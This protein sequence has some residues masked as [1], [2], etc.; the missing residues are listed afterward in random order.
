MAAV[1]GMTITGMFTIEVWATSIGSKIEALATSKDLQAT[2][3]K[4]AKHSLVSRSD[5]A[6]TLYFAGKHDLQQT[7]QQ[8][9]QQVSWSFQRQNPHSSNPHHPI[10]TN[11]I[12][13]VS[14]MATAT[15]IPDH[16]PSCTVGYCTGHFLDCNRA[17]CTDCCTVAHIH[18]SGCNCATD[19]SLG[20]SCYTL[21]CFIVHINTAAAV[22][23]H[24]L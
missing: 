18:Q 10:T 17:D 15:N 16:S 19:C 23:S 14:K 6:Q 21:H 2:S 20:H 4:F 7:A 12:Y 24:H 11:S 22:V 5:Y 1:F 3:M 8:L 13:S 9:Q